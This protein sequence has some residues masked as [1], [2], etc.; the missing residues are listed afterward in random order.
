[1]TT[2]ADELRAAAA[3][4]RGLASA[5][6][7]DPHSNR[8][9]VS[10]EFLTKKPEFP[11][12]FP[13]HGR[14]IAPDS[15]GRNRDLIHGGGGGTRA[16]SPWMFEAHGAYIAAMHPGVGKALADWLEYEAEFG[17]DPGIDPAAL[18]VA[19]VILGGHR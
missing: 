8:P 5:A 9:T 10:W 18:T 6:S 2:S 11:T 1:M 7:T 3:R 16:H 14:L 12:D 17:T 4:L 19:H 13:P 15:E